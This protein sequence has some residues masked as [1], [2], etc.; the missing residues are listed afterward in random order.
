MN[1]MPLDVSEKMFL[2]NLSE[3]VELFKRLVHNF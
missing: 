2:C 1:K 3:L